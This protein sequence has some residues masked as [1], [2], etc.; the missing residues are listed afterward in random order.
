MQEALIRCDS[1]LEDRVE[2]ISGSLKNPFLLLR[3]GV[4]FILFLPGLALVVVVLPAAS[5]PVL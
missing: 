5:L 3:E 2:H 4:Q 1:Q